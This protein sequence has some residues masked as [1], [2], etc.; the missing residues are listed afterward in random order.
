MTESRVPLHIH[1][2]LSLVIFVTAENT[3]TAVY[4]F[5]EL[6]PGDCLPRALPATRLLMFGR[7]V[8]ELGDLDLC[9]ACS[10]SV[11]GIKDVCKV[12]WKSNILSC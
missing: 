2:G 5:L 12:D 10:C 11:R 6:S 4:P 3:V 9:A 8:T 7:V 1:I